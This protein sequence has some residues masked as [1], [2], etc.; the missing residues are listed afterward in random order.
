[1][2]VPLRGIDVLRDDEL[3]CPLLSFK[4]VELG[5]REHAIVRRYVDGGDRRWDVY[6]HDFSGL[7]LEVDIVRCARRVHCGNRE[8]EAAVGALARDV[9]CVWTPGLITDER[10]IQPAE[11]TVFSFGMAHKIRADMFRRLR[12]LLDA[13]GRSYAVHVSAANHETA[14]LKDSEA[15]FAEMHE[16]FPDDLYFLGNLSDV[17]VLSYL[18]SATFFAAFFEGG[19]RANNTSIASAMERGAVVITNLDEYSPRELVHMQNVIDLEQCA[20]LPDDPLTLK[21]ISVEAM[22]YGRARGWSQLVDVLRS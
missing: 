7:D 16:I 6:L 2:E 11:I 9:R 10:R 22:K 20:A 13:S 12:T 4:V 19:A 8:I 18:T 1:L 3:G 15:V 17:A 14:S 5:E 21:Q